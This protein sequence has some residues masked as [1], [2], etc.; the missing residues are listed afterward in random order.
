[1][2]RAFRIIIVIFIILNIQI[3]NTSGET[4]NLIEEKLVN[5]GIS[6][7]YSENIT[8]YISNL[9][10]SDEEANELLVNVNEI[11]SSLTNKENYNDFTFSELVSIYG[12]ALNI[13][14]RLNI[15]VDLDFFNKEVVLKDKESKLILIKC[16]LDDAKRYY[17]NYKESPLTTEDYDNLKN[18]I[19]ESIV[20]N[21]EEM[22]IVDNSKNN[23][24]VENIN[25]KSEQK[26]EEKQ[27][28]NLELSE[29]SYNQSQENNEVLN[30]VSSIKKKNVNRVLSIVFLVLI[31]CVI[32]S[33][34]IDTIFFEKGE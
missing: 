33:L 10:I 9:K 3:V 8:N 6:E 30:R 26:L 2:K 29:N 32:I 5:V 21:D 1:M 14:E 16:D 22:K 25:A 31:S 12:E 28:E 7:E 27:E 19:S 24:E 13:A 17:E 4:L 34:L 11:I 20:S 18:Y 23:E 15:N